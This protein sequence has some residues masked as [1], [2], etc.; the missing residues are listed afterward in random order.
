MLLLP[1]F[2]DGRA[3]V[4]DSIPQKADTVKLQT[5]EPASLRDSLLNYSYRFLGRHYRRGG[6]SPK[7]GF[8][9]SGYTM[10]VYSRVGIRLPHTSAG[11]A[12]VGFEVNRKN[13]RKGDLIFFKGRSR[14]SR[15]IGHVGMVISKK[16]EAIKF[17]HS[18]VKDGVRIDALEAEYYRK[19]FVK[20]VRVVN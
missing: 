11:Q 4:G 1:L 20:V 16:G 6:T 12:L 17:I 3:Q 9:C 18:S 13:A 5:R 10:L 14:K 15:R 2:F 8:D 19:R 7:K